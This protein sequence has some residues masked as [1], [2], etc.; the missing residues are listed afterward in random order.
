MPM[1][2]RTPAAMSNAHM[3]MPET[4]EFDPPTRPEM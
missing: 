1:A 3:V 2:N 4:G